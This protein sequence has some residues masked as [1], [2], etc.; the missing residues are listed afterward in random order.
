MDIISVIDDLKL[1]D[2]SIQ[3]IIFDFEKEILTIDVLRLESEGVISMNFK[4]VCNIYFDNIECWTEL[5]LYK[6]NVDKIE[7][8]KYN[9]NIIVMLGFALPSWKIIFNFSDFEL[10]IVGKE[11]T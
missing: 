3:K 6:I 1:H 2:S 8:G 9:V 4:K 11:H 5:D 10:F 7:D